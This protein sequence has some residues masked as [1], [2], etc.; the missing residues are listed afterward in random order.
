MYWCKI[1]RTEKEFEDIAKLN[2]KTFVEEIPQHQANG[3]KV[4]I[5]P[6]HTE[7]TYLLVY[8]DTEM[9]GMLAFRDQRPFSLDRKI[10]PVEEKLN[11]EDCQKLC[12]IRLLSVKKD[13][14]NGRVFQQLAKAIYTFVYDRGY[15][16]AVISGTTREE[17]LYSQLGFQQFA[18]KMGT[19]D[20]TFLPM[21]LTRKNSEQ[22][23]N[24]IHIKNY[25]FY[26]GPTEQIHPLMNTSTSHR[27]QQFA[28]MFEE[29]KK[30]LL[31]IAKTKYVTT[32]VG[33]GTLAND[34]MLGQMKAEFKESKGLMISNG[35]FGERLIRQAKKWKL[36]FDVCSYKW[37]EAF[38]LLEIEQNLWTGLYDWVCFIHGET[39]TGMC[40][41]LEPM[42]QLAKK[43]R[44]KVCA[45][46]ISSFGSFL[47]SMENLHMAT[48]VS[49]KSLG[50]LS[51]LA[52]V[53]SNQQPLK[54]DAPLY[55]NLYY[56]FKNSLPFTMPAF[57]VSN[58]LFALQQYPE[59]FTIL[60]ERMNQVIES[61]FKPFSFI[62]SATYP[63]IMS[64][65]M[66]AELQYFSE[67]AKLNGL[68]LHDE[69]NY[70]KKR[71]ITQI[72]VIS[73]NFEQ[74]FKK[75]QAFYVCYNQVIAKSTPQA[76]VHE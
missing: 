29:M 17:K 75:L 33:T 68:L 31:N 22:M 74:A 56:Y 35:E 43:Y 55:L 19:E 61:P 10:G 63:M 41:D 21:I 67:D 23:I 36:N 20:A 54:N 44:V 40:N 25:S 4:L 7:N 65:N 52:F 2:Y 59:R 12:E 64:M 73:P 69:S 58:T 1:A 14:R 53:F 8:K 46:C 72:S 60:Q 3:E 76:Q 49:G 66:S 6:F 38:N 15:T 71:Q 9:V 26:P 11:Q 48:A 47:F 39:S 28:I 45:D 70:L 27:S 18:E 50:A 32:L 24:R 16:A 13:F 37:G 30:Q 42:L 34:V 51:G 62:Q 57:L 5:D